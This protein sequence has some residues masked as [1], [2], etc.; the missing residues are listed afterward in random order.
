[1]AGFLSIVQHLPKEIEVVV[2]H[3]LTSAARSAV[4]NQD[5]LAAERRVA[6]PPAAENKC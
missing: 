2:W 5:Q 4:S 3:L 6:E 1:M